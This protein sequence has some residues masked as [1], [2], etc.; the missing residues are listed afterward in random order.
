M[1]ENNA[2]VAHGQA[3]PPDNDRPADEAPTVE[4]TTS[5]FA[6]LRRRPR[7]KLTLWAPDGR[8]LL[9]EQHHSYRE[10]LDAAVSFCRDMR[11]GP[12]T[13]DLAA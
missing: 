10:A 6:G 8:V 7:W 3:A 11:L 5:W 2:P 13:V 9:K 12:V 4:I 1:H